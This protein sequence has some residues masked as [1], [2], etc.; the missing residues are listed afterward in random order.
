MTFAPLAAFPAGRWM[1]LGSSGRL[2]AKAFSLSA[3]GQDNTSLQQRIGVLFQRE[4]F[5]GG[6]LSM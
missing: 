4:E 3:C 1:P 2:C 5:S 6:L